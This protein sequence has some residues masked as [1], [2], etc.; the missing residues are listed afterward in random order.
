MVG[1]CVVLFLDCR[2]SIAVTE[3]CI[4]ERLYRVGVQ[5]KWRYRCLE[6]ARVEGSVHGWLVIAMRA[7]ISRAV[8]PR[9]PSTCDNPCECA[10][11]SHHRNTQHGRRR[12]SGA[13][14]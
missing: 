9:L 14:S 12:P 7:Y 8:G 1:D 13:V 4:K 11:N 3:G 5:C 10:Y 6:E 2:A